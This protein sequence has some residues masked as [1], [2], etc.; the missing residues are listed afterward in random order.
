MRNP[1]VGEQAQC[2]WLFVCRTCMALLHLLQQLFAGTATTHLS[3]PRL[4]QPLT[5]ESQV[6]ALTVTATPFQPRGSAKH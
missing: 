2:L 1:H 3:M 5:L 4:Q 6:R